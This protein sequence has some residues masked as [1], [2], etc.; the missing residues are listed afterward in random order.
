MKRLLKYVLGFLIGAVGALAATFLFGCYFIGD[1]GFF[2]VILSMPLTALI[3]G[4]IGAVSSGRVYWSNRA[5]LR[6]GVFTLIGAILG[7]ALW[8]LIP[9]QSTDPKM[10]AIWL[11]PGR[12][13]QQAPFGLVFGVAIGAA[14]G[15]IAVAI[16]GANIPQ[17]TIHIGA[18]ADDGIWP[19]A[20]TRRS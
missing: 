6:L 12:M 4:A 3:G 1:D 7:A 5:L 18:N 2:F 8:V 14:V 16:W 20:P 11:T 13:L 19:P 17:T 10:L 15:Q 9:S